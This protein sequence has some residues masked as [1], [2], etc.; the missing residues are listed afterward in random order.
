MVHRIRAT[1]K[2]KIL[3]NH[4]RVKPEHKLL[5]I[6]FLSLFALFTLFILF[7]RLSPNYLT[8]QATNAS[9]ATTVYVQNSTTATCNVTLPQGLSLFSLPCIPISFPRSDFFENLS[10]DGV[11]VI[12]MYKYVPTQNGRWQVYNR[13]LPNYTVQTLNTFSKDNGIYIDMGAAEQFYYQGYLTQTPS[14]TLRVGWNLVG[15]PSIITRTIDNALQS[16][17]S[18]Y[19]I[20][21]TLEGTTA[22]G[23]H[24]ENKS[25]GSGNLTNT[26]TYQGY[27]INVTAIDNWVLS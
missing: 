1:M 8:A 3:P 19:T 9:V 4:K 25:D 13:D 11:N 20:I 2:H 21:R 12:S 5:A 7:S 26:S 16:I 18:T 6:I 15:Y 27:W 22:T 17:Q 14:I 10:A 24:Y 23:A